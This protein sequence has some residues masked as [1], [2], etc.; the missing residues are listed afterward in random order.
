MSDTQVE[1]TP[2]G[3]IAQTAVRLI[4]EHGWTQRWMGAA[5]VGYCLLGACAEAC[6]QKVPDS[7]RC[8]D[9]H[10]VKN[11]REIPLVMEL[12]RLQKRVFK[13]L[14][15]TLDPG[16]GTPTAIG[17]WNDAADRTVEEVIDVLQAVSY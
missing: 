7:F 14:N 8:P 3:L 2:A 1:A 11:P 17:Q 5:D 6:H 4:R 9:S 13:H 10:W 15:L 16:V 12:I